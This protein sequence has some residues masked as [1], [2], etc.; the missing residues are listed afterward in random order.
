MRS[1]L[2]PLVLTGL[3]MSCSSDP[4]T[5]CEP[6]HVAIGSLKA[7]D[8]GKKLA[9]SEGVATVAIAHA[10]S[11]TATSPG[12]VSQITAVFTE[13]DGTCEFTVEIGTNSGKPLHVTHATL[14]TTDCVFW[15]EEHQAILL[16]GPAYDVTVSVGSSAGDGGDS[17]CLES[18]LSLN[19]P[20]ILTTEE[21]D[22][23]LEVELD[24][25]GATG[26][27]D[28]TGQSDLTCPGNTPLTTPEGCELDL[29]EA[30]QE[31]GQCLSGICQV[32]EI[33]P[34]GICTLPC[35]ILT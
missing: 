11:E 18:P 32:S 2:I 17:G 21:G 35:R 26:I 34:F 30:C 27:F 8:I 5:P 24:G 31:D 10:S 7:N 15:E 25:L 3:L 23:T 6:A 22:L 28:S 16:S 9:Y 12:C 19:G 20:L 33:T 14:D 4:A 13:A 1:L 29:G